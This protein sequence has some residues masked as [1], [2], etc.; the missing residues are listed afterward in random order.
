ME[1]ALVHPDNAEQKVFV[2]HPQQLAAYE[3]SGF[4]E[5]NEEQP[6]EEVSKKKLSAKAA[7]EESEGEK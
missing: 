1:M 5:V 7:K 3:A 4:I 6:D 2:T